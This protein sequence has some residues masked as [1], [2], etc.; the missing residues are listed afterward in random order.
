M[1][2]FSTSVFV[3]FY[4]FFLF[5]HFSLCSI[6]LQELWSICFHLKSFCR[7]PQ[8]ALHLQM[9]SCNISHRLSSISFHMNNRLCKWTF[10]FFWCTRPRINAAS[11]LKKDRE[12]FIERNCC[13][14]HMACYSKLTKMFIIDQT[15]RILTFFA[16]FKITLKSM[17]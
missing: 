16:V 5:Y 9:F 2:N 6:L 11:N 1:F 8:A 15:T 7:C 17:K 13:G 10:Y 12:M 14:K 3:P 4:H